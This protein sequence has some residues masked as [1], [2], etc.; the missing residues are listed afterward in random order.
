MSNI[1]AFNSILET[2][3]EDAEDNNNDNIKDIIDGIL[4]QNDLNNVQTLLVAIVRLRLYQAIKI[5]CSKN[6]F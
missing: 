5:L 1:P 2:F 4:N 3:P 6:V